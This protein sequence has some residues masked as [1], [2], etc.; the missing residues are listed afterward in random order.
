MGVAVIRYSEQPQLWQS[1]EA[2][3]RERCGPST[4]DVSG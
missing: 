2:L 1:T 3:T 4:T